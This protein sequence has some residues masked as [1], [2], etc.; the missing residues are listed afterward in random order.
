[1]CIS[2]CTKHTGER[3]PVWQSGIYGDVE[4]DYIGAT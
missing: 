3:V 4:I 2:D 1:M